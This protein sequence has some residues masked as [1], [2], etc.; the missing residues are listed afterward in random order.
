M[1]IKWSVT[2]SDARRLR[3]FFQDNKNHP[4]VRQ[5]QRVN[6]RRKQKRPSKAVFWKQMVICLASTQQR[7][8]KGS[9]LEA[10]IKTHPFPLPYSKCSK[11]RGLKRYIQSNLSQYEGMRWRQN[12]A[13]QVTDNYIRLENG[14]WAPWALPHFGHRPAFAFA[15]LVLPAST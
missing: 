9:P 11:V 2:A 3:A 13:D 10:L 5:R 8:G 6:L 7:S 15:S 14:L 4:A 1:R 12:I